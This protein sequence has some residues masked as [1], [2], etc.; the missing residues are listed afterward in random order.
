MEKRL[1]AREMEQGVLALGERELVERAAIAHSFGFKG[2][3][4]QKLKEA[5]EMQYM[6]DSFDRPRVN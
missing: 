1:I 5:W 6:E 4:L 3:H 2:F